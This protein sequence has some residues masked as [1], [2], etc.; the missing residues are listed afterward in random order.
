[1]LVGSRSYKLIGC[2][3]AVVSKFDFMDQSLVGSVVIGVE[4]DR[5]DHNS[6]LRNQIKLMVK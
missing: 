2:I 3:F 5:E 1:M 6:I 4:F